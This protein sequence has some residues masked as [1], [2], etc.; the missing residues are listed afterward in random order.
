MAVAS[1][2]GEPLEQQHADALAPAGAVGGVA[3]GLAAPVGRRPRWRL[4][5]VNSPGVAITLTPPASASEHSPWRSALAA[6]CSATS[7]EEHAVST[8]TAGPSKPKVYATRPETTLAMPPVSRY[9]SS[10]SAPA[11]VSEA[12]TP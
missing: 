12:P 5:S 3:E 11:L 7:E 9:P 2:V 10:S 8:D 1:R 4:N 6:R